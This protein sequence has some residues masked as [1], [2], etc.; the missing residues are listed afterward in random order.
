MTRIITAVKKK[1]F[2]FSNF[3][4]HRFVEVLPSGGL[5]YEQAK[6]K[7]VGGISRVGTVVERLKQIRPNPILLNAGDSFQGTLYYDLFKGNITAQF[8]NKLK[9]DAHVSTSM[10]VQLFSRFYDND[11]FDID[12]R[13]SRYG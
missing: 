9:I 5:C 1:I 7:C 11:D 12:I 4:N 3:F 2:F 8:M 13:K 10:I 6:D